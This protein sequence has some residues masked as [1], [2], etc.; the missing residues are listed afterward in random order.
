LAAEKLEKRLR[1]KDLPQRD[2]SHRSIGHYSDELKFAT[3][4]ED[5]IAQIMMETN[6]SCLQGESLKLTETAHSDILNHIKKA[7]SKEF[8]SLIQDGVT[9]LGSSARID[10]PTQANSK[11]DPGSLQNTQPKLCEKISA[12]SE[13][14]NTHRK[15]SGVL[16]SSGFGQSTG[17]P[18]EHRDTAPFDLSHSSDSQVRK[19]SLDIP[20]PDLHVPG[21]VSPLSLSREFTEKLYEQISQKVLEYVKKEISNLLEASASV[22]VLNSARSLPNL[23]QESKPATETEL[24]KGFASEQLPDRSSLANA[25]DDK[26]LET[27]AE[28][29][30]EKTDRT[31]LFELTKTD[32]TQLFE[33]TSKTDRHL[34]TPKTPATPETFRETQ[35][36][37]RIP[38]SLHETSWQQFED[39]IKCFEQNLDKISADLLVHPKTDST[40]DEEIQFTKS[41][42]S[43]RTRSVGDLSYEE[44]EFRKAIK[45]DS[46]DIKEI[47]GILEKIEKSSKSYDNSFPANEVHFTTEEPKKSTN[48]ILDALKDENPYRKKKN[49]EGNIIS[50]HLIH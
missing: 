37:S 13:E 31:Q 21:N 46:F 42:R 3:I 40:E 32:R 38:M 15:N 16:F 29:T 19:H 8:D 25:Y 24:Q 47:E 22:S 43:A 34:E 12:L 5:L 9:S 44:N 45:N 2:E 30:I 33:L 18:S 11:V 39:K 23:N 49:M 10:Q 1:L 27:I 50:T 36:D 28:K 26:P 6:R 7:V 14:Q 48:N 41:D 17:A 4:K 35:R 20:K